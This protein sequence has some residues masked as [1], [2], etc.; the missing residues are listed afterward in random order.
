M[1][2]FAGKARNWKL[3]SVG[4]VVLTLAVGGWAAYRATRDAAMLRV[5]PDDLSGDAG[6]Y[7]F[8]V[9]EGRGVFASHCANCHGGDLKG[10]AI[11]GVPNLTDA[12]WLFGEGRVAQ[13]EQTVLYGIRAGTHRTKNLADMP[14]FGREHP[15][16]RYAVDPL[17]ATEMDD[18]ANYIGTFQGRTADP[19]SLAR[20]KALFNFKGQCFDC[21]GYD[22]VGDDFIGAPNLADN[23]WLYGDGSHDAIVDSISMGR[24]GVS[25]MFK[26]RLSAA[27]IRAVSAYVHAQSKPPPAA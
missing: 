25:P 8:A 4:L 13:I 7:R 14:A 11:E 6:L 17:K 19:S 10:S 2:L 16:A 3:L 21:H 26:D 12:D 1:R 23:I 15:Y 5:L 18:I 22:L 20:G 27:Q 9:D 24:Q